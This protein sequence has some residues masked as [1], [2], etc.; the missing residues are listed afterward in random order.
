M[1]LLSTPSEWPA[2]DEEPPPLSEGPHL[3]P[4]LAQCDAIDDPLVE[5]TGVPTIDAYAILGILPPRPARV[6]SGVH[7]RLIAARAAL[8][9]GFDLVVLDGWRT[10]GDQSAL[11]DHYAK[12]G[13]T[14]GWVADPTADARPPH[15]TGGTVDLTLSYDGV[16]L[17]L[18]SDFDAFDDTAHLAALEGSDH[19]ARNLRRL[20]GAV[21]ATQGFV[22]YALEW[23]HWSH[24]D[25]TWSAATGRPAKYDIAVL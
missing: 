15:M 18:G 25:D 7:D 8:P 1:E 13:P 17:A 19:P 21:L 4:R 14:D 24:G 11:V 22:G 5:I 3:S 23:W 9:S 12:E 20:L 2:L 10:I 6:R 16:A